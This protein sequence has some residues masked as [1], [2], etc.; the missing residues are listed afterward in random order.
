M[1]ASYNVFLLK[2]Y[3]ISIRLIFIKILLTIF[4]LFQIKVA[5]SAFG[6]ICIFQ[7][8]KIFAKQFCLLNMND[9]RQK[10][11]WCKLTSFSHCNVSMEKQLRSHSIDLCCGGRIDK[12]RQSQ[13]GQ[14]F[15]SEANDSYCLY[16]SGQIVRHYALLVW[17]PYKS[18]SV[19]KTLLENYVV[20]VYKQNRGR[21]E[22]IHQ[23][24]VSDHWS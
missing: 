15:K 11:I 1:F 6:H 18:D 24:I 7:H 21:M 14:I 13:I 9:K 5:T 19:E 3:N 16:N 22:A 20:F 12:I 17:L 8:Q 10:C 4:F 23:G 2:G